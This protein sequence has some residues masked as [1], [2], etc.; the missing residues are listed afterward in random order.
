MLALIH[1]SF[2]ADQQNDISEGV[3]MELDGRIGRIKP[4]TRRKEE[5]GNNELRSFWLQ[6]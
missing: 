4:A 3:L 6:K 1:L 2:D 5:V